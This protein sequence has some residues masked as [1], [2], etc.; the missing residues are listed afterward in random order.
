VTGIGGDRD[1]ANNLK[2]VQS[3]AG[4][5]VDDLTWDGA[6]TLVENGA[7]WLTEQGDAVTQ[8]VINEAEAD[9]A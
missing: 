4:E 7:G 9:A 2:V 3:N 8:A 6:I 5:T 1:G